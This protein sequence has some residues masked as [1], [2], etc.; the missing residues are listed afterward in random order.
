MF[1]STALDLI[2][3][4]FGFTIPK[5]VQQIERKAEMGVKVA[6]C[7]RTISKCAPAVLAVGVLLNACAQQ[8]LDEDYL[9]FVPAFLLTDEARA[10]AKELKEFI[11]NYVRAHP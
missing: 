5:R 10:C 11:A 7:S 8:G 2:D 4:I 3:K 6:C 9:D 1:L